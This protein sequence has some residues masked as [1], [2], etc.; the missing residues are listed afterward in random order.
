MVSALKESS[1]FG[2]RLRA[3]REAAGLTQTQLEELTGVKREYISSIE[4]GRIAV[5]Y[6]EVFNKLH[7]VLRFEGWVL[8]EAM[9]YE[10]DAGS[11][12]A[13]LNPALL[14]VVSRL[15]P[16][17]QEA[18]M[19]FLISFGVERRDGSEDELR[20]ARSRKESGDGPAKS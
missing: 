16:K 1:R 15:T 2:E 3:Y 6:P 11:G 7:A 4:L 17:Q 5:V 10:T 9:G 19:Q 14:A 20:R 13:E 18:L 8:L 12:T